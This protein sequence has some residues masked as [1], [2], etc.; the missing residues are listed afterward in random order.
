VSQA[1]ID[2][3]NRV[4]LEVA[5][6][7]IGDRSLRELA[8]AVGTSH[9]ML[10]YHFGSR[11]GLVAAIVEAVEA[12][13]RE[14]FRHA[15]ADGGDAEEVARAT[16]ASVTSPDVLPF[17]RLFFEAVV[18][19]SRHGGAAFT[20]PS[21]E[22]AGLAAQQAGLAPDPVSAR[23]AV[24]VVRGLLIDVVTEDHPEQADAA[25]ELFLSLLPPTDDAARRPREQP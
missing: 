21:L 16:W 8:D 1:R 22:T 17:V 2:L 23:L 13:Q 19:A 12:S 10:I 7:G 11:D 18:Y 6:H 5:A 9:R 3:L 25:F 15:A 14:V 20:A 24:A 4:I